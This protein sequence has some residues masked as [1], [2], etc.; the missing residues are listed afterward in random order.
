M[1]DKGVEE[2]AA[3]ERRSIGD[4]LKS[5]CMQINKV[6]IYWQRVWS[7]AQSTDEEE[8]GSVAEDFGDRGGRYVESSELMLQ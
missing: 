8:G 2:S 6:M 7:P 3:N 1:I 5:V 4:E